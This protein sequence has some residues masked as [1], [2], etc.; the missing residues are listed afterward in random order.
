M[1]DDSKVNHNDVKLQQSLKAT[2]TVNRPFALPP[3]GSGAHAPS[4]MGTLGVL[5]RVRALAHAIIIHKVF[6]EK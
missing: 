3:A 6:F 4:Q 5:D 2:V 1:V